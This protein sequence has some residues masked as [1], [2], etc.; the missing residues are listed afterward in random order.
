MQSKPSSDLTSLVSKILAHPELIEEISSLL[1]E[2]DSTAVANE[3]KEEPTVADTPPVRPKS[4]LK[5]ENRRRLLAAVRPLL[6]ER[7]ARALDSV[8][9]VVTLFDLGR[10]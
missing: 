8:E 3:K 9:T 1:T 5:E 6:S 7:R 2:N 4:S 10:R